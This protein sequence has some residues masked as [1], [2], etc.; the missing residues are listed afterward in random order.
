LQYN[1]TLTMKTI[2]L[3]RTLINILFFT[4][5]AVFAIGF[6]CTLILFI[7]PDSLP[8][9]LSG[10][11]MLFNNLFSWQMYLVPLITGI[12]Y[13]LFIIAIFYLKKSVSSFIESDYYSEK[14]T[15]NFK[16]A[17][18]IFIFIGVSTIVIQLFA[19]QYVQSIANNMLQMKTNYLISILNTL[20]AAIDLKSVLAIIIGLFFLLFSKIFENSRILKQENDLTI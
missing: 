7:S 3:L 6:M 13:I 5:I 1:Y 2:Q 12:N 15:T 8:L 9:P 4:L 18:N 17:G 11:S 19:V 14:A 20:A 16:K 10:F